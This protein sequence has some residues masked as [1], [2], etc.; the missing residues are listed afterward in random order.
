MYIAGGNF[1]FKL[2]S[3]GRIIQGTDRNIGLYFDATYRTGGG[4]RWGIYCEIIRVYQSYNVTYVKLLLTV[5]LNINILK[6]CNW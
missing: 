1:Q 2:G 4:A 5:S 6:Y 3:S